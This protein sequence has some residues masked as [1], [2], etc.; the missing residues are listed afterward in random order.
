MNAQF[1]HTTK[2]LNVKIME[3]YHNPQL[4]TKDWL[5]NIAIK[6]CVQYHIG[7]LE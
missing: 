7:R 3:V 4:L 1:K 6:S 2:L 5:P